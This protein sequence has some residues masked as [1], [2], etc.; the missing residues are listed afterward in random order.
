MFLYVVSDFGAVSLVRYDTLTTRIESARLFDPPT[1]LVLVALSGVL[2][3]FL[4]IRH[5]ERVA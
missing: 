3:W 1:A 4:T 5:M 2:T